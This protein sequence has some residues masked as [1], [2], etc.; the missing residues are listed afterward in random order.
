MPSWNIINV[1]QGMSK[2]QR[3]PG[4]LKWLFSKILVCTV[5]ATITCSSAS[6]AVDAFQD[7]KNDNFDNQKSNLASR[8]K[9]ILSRNRKK[10][11]SNSNQRQEQ[12]RKE[13][14]LCEQLGSGGSG[15]VYRAI[16]QDEIIAVKITKSKY[17]WF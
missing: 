14:Q 9:S 16:S 5:T 7:I 10:G 11:N 1:G 15:H 6:L 3:I 12:K 8:I 2:V 17:N 13:F 4:L